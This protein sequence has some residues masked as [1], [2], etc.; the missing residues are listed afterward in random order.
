MNIRAKIDCEFALRF[1]LAEALNQ[2]EEFK[3][4][5]EKA[6][7]LMIE[8]VKSGKEFFT[9]GNGGSALQAAHITVEL[10][11]RFKRDRRPIPALCLNTDIAKITALSNDFGYP[12][13]FVRQLEARCK[14]GDVVI[15]LTTSDATEDND[16]SRNILEAFKAAK[17]KGAKCIGLFSAKTQNLLNWVDVAIV[18]P[19]LDGAFIQEIHDQIIH[20]LC[21]RVEEGL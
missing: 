12:A 1:R 11:G 6:A 15:G 16:H 19:S 20:T 13:V 8:A 3:R 17:S 4:Q 21:G 2:D 10:E 9:F 5:I 14:E 18:V 7:R